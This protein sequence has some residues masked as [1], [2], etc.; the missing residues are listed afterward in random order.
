MPWYPANPPV[1]S[2]Q[3]APMLVKLPIDDFLR[4]FTLE[5]NLEARAHFGRLYVPLAGTREANVLLP[6][7][8]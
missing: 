2:V 6:L 1:G 7:D 5:W 3:N 8:Q 4:R